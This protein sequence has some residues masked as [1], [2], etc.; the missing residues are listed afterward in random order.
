VFHA[1]LRVSQVSKLLE[2]SPALALVHGCHRAW[3]V[4]DIK[5][6]CTEHIAPA[7][8]AQAPE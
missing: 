1:F 6:V 2:K 8:S 3:L 5:N 4:F 7:V